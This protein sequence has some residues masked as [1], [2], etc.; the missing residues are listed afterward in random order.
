[1]KTAVI[2]AVL[3]AF[4]AIPIIFGRKKPELL[5]IKSPADPKQIDVNVRYDI[6]DFM[7]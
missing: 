3:G 7:T 5:P 2:T 1:M 6:D 4:A